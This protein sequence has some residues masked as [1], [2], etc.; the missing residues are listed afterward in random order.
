MS[1]GYKVLAP[2]AGERVCRR[3]LEGESFIF[4][5]DYLFTK[6]EVWLPFLNFEIEVLNHLQVSPSQL[7]P[8]GWGFV[9]VFE[10]VCK[11]YG[12]EPSLR[13]FFYLFEVYHKK[14][15]RGESFVSV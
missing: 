4:M 7:H 5:Y 11:F 1:K 13:V 2:S 10:R 15:G 3:W 12:C 9:K 8:N 6:I 14:E